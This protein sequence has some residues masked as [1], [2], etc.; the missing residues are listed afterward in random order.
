[1]KATI[2]IEKGNVGSD[3]IIDVN[4][5]NFSEHVPVLTKY[6]NKVGEAIPFIENNELKAQLEINDSIINL[7]PSVGVKLIDYRMSG[8]VL[9]ADKSKLVCINLHE[10]PNQDLSIKKIKDQISLNK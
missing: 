9:F 2:V 7:F 6:N 5:I 10:S 3:F 4:G 8:P 1:M